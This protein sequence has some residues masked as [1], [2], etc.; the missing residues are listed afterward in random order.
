MFW[1]NTCTKHDESNESI[2][3]IAPVIGQPSDT[4]RAPLDVSVY[5]KY[6]ALQGRASQEYYELTF[7]LIQA[8]LGGI[9]ER[10]L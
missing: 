8:P 2:G 7:Q 3:W 9:S 5:Y 4:Y 1:C 10:D 6:Q